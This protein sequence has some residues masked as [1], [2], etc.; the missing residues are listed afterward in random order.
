MATECIWAKSYFLPLS[1]AFNLMNEGFIQ[2]IDTALKL[3]L[4]VTCIFIQD[5]CVPC[6]HM[7]KVIFKINIFQNCLICLVC[8]QNIEEENMWKCVPE[9]VHAWK[10]L[11]VGEVDVIDWT[12]V[13]VH[14]LL[15]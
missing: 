11:W 6:C 1:K 4:V 3:R 2:S 15:I 13:R 12:K 8:S 10:D 9:Q 7:V 5:Q 14:L